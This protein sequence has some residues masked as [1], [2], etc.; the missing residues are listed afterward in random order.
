MNFNSASFESFAQIAREKP[1]K[2]AL[3]SLGSEYSE[4][5]SKWFCLSNNMLYYFAKE[6]AP[7]PEGVVLLPGCEANIIEDDSVSPSF[8]LTAGS[9]NLV[10]TAPSTEALLGE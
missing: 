5:T 8:E 3:L 1:D 10:L 6:G 2:A 7:N 4:S 9:W